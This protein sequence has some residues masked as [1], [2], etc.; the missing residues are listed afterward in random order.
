MDDRDPIPISALQH[1][2]DCPRQCCLIHLEQA[3]EKNVNTLRGRAVHSAGDAP[4]LATR[5]GCGL[6]LA[7]CFQVGVLR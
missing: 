4:G 7:R 5:A 6:M 1:R 3:L 2:C